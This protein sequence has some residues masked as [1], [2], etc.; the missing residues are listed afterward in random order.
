NTT[1][2]NNYEIYARQS[3]DGGVTWGA[4]SALSDVLIPE[5]VQ[6]DPLVQPF[7]GGDY[8]FT[9]SDQ[10]GGVHS[11]RLLTTWTDGRNLLLS[12]PAGSYDFTAGSGTISSG[13]TDVGNHCDDC[14]TAASL[15]FSVTYFGT[16]YSSVNVSSN[17]SVQFGG[18]N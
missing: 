15:P 17:G 5:P 3:T 8:N 10:T 6:N 7:Y 2:G 14:T 9:S 18:S 12:G 16:P 13:G 1:D 11:A 4:A